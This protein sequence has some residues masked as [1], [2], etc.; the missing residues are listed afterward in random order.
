[1]S[2]PLVVVPT[3]ILVTSCSSTKLESFYRDP[4]PAVLEKFTY[5]QFVE[6]DKKIKEL[7]PGTVCQLEG[8]IFTIFTPSGNSYGK[9]IVTLTPNKENMFEIKR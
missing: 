4:T 9:T 3:T 6:Y 7:T 8:D 2:L 5:E 1:M